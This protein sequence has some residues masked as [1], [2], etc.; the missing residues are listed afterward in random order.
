MTSHSRLLILLPIV[1]LGFQAW[2]QKAPSPD[3]LTRAAES[4]RIYL[5]EQ[6]LSRGADPDG[7]DG[8]GRTALLKAVE[9]GDWAMTSRLLDAGAHPDLPG[10]DG[11]TPLM[12]AVRK[13]REDLALLLLV[14]GAD[15]DFITR[16]ESAL[17]LSIS[18]GEFGIARRLVEYGADGLLLADPD[19]SAPNPLGL[20]VLPVLLD[21]RAWRDAASLRLFASPPD[22]DAAAGEGGF[23]WSLH[24]AARD[25]DWRAV[26]DKLD[27]GVSPDT[28]DERG[29][30]PLMTASFFGHDSVTALLLQRGA[31]PL[32]RDS[33]GRDA[34]CYAALTGRGGTLSRLISAAAAKGGGL[35]EIRPEPAPMSAS[36]LYYALIGHQREVLNSLLAAG[37][38]PDV[39][40][41]EGI[42]LLM[43]AAWLGD[44]YAVGRLLPLTDGTWS[45]GNLKEAVRDQAGRTAL[46]WSLAA[47]RR[48]RESGRLLGEEDRGARNYPAA[49]LLAGRH[50]NPEDYLTRPARDAHPDV[51]TAWS[52][53][54]GAADRADDWRYLVPSPVPAVPGDG[55]LTLYRILR[56][57][58]PGTPA[59]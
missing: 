44:T 24:R 51:I 30:T 35:P 50:R 47:F 25:N 32:L 9:S 43:F 27:A 13:S 34:L 26:R 4:G 55:D 5:V 58:E 11:F 36:P 52:P 48:D 8:T 45:G 37:Y 56:D 10:P 57:E 3:E 21:A 6:L 31:D 2:A 38:P 59:E 28:V 18:A 54:S 41:S 12:K 20:P 1:L 17:S 40:D 23:R 15:P 42:T 14:R 16:S 33:L 53:G 7:V 29:V 46:D 19:P 22:W 49:R 39:S